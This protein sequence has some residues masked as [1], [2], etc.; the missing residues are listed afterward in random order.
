MGDPI[1]ALQAREIVGQIQSKNLLANTVATG[2]YL[3]NNLATLATKHPQKFQDLRGKG[4]GTF[5]AWTLRYCVCLAF[6]PA[7]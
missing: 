1:R 4:Q 7:F 6:L 2:D 5:I 3:Y